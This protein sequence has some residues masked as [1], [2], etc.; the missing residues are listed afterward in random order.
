MN[1]YEAMFTKVNVY[2]ACLRTLFT[3]RG[4]RLRS[5]NVDEA[6]ECLRGMNVYE[7]V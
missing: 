4:E 6:P 1:V 2:E 3:K 5:L 7:A